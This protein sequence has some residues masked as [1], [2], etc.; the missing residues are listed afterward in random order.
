LALA[1]AHPPE[2]RGVPPNR[3][4]GLVPQEEPFMPDPVQDAAAGGSSDEAG[5]LIRAAAEP[6]P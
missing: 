6:L 5:R 2:G 4:P 1:I 3:L